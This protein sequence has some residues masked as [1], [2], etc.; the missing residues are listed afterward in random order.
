MK[1][2]FVI[3]DTDNESTYLT[4]NPKKATR[5]NTVQ[6]ASGLTKEGAKKYLRSVIDA[7]TKTNL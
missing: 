3:R 1:E 5:E 6:M 4:R 2:Y 7:T